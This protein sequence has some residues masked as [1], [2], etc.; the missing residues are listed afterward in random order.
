MEIRIGI[1]Q[2]VRE[3]T[4]EIDDEKA[5][6]KFKAASELSLIHI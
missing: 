5:Q 1:I 2:S 4:L 3:I 6:S